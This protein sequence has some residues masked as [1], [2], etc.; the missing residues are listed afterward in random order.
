MKVQ[1]RAMFYL[2]SVV[3]CDVLERILSASGFI[4]HKQLSERLEVAKSNV[5]S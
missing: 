4:M 2:E 3:A 5:A 1:L